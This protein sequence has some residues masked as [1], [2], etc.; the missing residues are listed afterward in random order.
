MKKL[1]L[2]VIFLLVSCAEEVKEKSE[3][4]KCI[5]AN[6][7]LIKD[8]DLKKINIVLPE[9]LKLKV[10][11]DSELFRELFSSFETAKMKKISNFYKTWDELFSGNKEQA[12]KSFKVL[13]EIE[14]IDKGVNINLDKDEIY[15][16]FS[17]DGED[18]TIGDIS[19]IFKSITTSSSMEEFFS[20]AYLFSLKQDFQN[21][22]DVD[23]GLQPI[24]SSTIK[25][26]DENTFKDI[27]QNTCWSQ[28]IY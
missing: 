1:S 17:D 14:I 5:D 28:G 26:T 7:S 4:E 6:V 24:V 10:R 8:A 3:L 22:D 18:L 19:K 27:A 21:F 13:Q 15:F 12:V 16:T 9:I 11:V 25:L 20:D 2:L 23:D